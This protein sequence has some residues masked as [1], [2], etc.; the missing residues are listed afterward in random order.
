MNPHIP[1][2]YEKEEIKYKLLTRNLEKEEPLTE[3]ELNEQ[4]Y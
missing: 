1:I 4:G 3:K 2:V